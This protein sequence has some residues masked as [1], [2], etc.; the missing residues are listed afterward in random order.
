MAEYSTTSI[1]KK[2]AHAENAM[3]WIL[4][5]YGLAG[6]TFVVAAHMAH[7]YGG[8][9]TGLYVFPFVAFLGGVA[10]FLAAMSAYRKFDGLATAM[11]GTWGSFWMAY[12]LLNLLAATGRLNLPTS[13]FP[14]MGFWFIALACITWMGAIAAASESIALA[15]VF[16]FLA[17]AS[18]LAAIAD[19]AG[20]ETLAIIAGWL[21]IVGAVCAWYAASALMFVGAFGR[22]VLP[23]GSIEPSAEPRSH[24]GFGTA[25]AL[26]EAESHRAA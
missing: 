4:G 24:L 26:N 7:W 12:G 19:L 2:R 20:V 5:L 14:A 25:P 6:A 15:A 18:T 16:T 9:Q 1:A 11:L 3:P 17:A 10:T 8:P 21:F 23:V 13:T 22:Q